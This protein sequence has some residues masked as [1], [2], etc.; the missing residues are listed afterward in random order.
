MTKKKKKN[1]IRISALAMSVGV[2][3][4]FV[5]RTFGSESDGNT[6]SASSAVTLIN[7]SVKTNTEDFFDENVVYKLSDNVSS[8]QE[9]SVIVAMN[10]D[11]VLDAYEA[12]DQKRSVKE[13][14]TTGEARTVAQ[15]T[16]AARNRL[17]K[18]L[19]KSGVKYVLGEKYDTV[20]SGFEITIK[21]KDFETVGGLFAADAT[22]ILGEVYAP[23]ESQVITNDVDVYDTGIFDSSASAYQGDGVVV[24][25]LDTG[26]DYTHTAFS[27]DNFTTSDEAFTL[28]TVAEKIGKTSAAKSSAGLSAEDVYV[29]KK[30]PYAYD[31]ADK[32]AD[33]APINSAHGTHVAGVIAGKDDTITGVAPNAQLA[34]MKVFSDTQDGAKTSWLLAALEDC[35]TL[36][37]DVINMS[38][39]SGCGFTREV[40]EEKVAEVCD[41]IRAAGI[42]LVVSAGNAYNATFNSEKNGNNGL[43]SNPDSGTVSSPSTYEASLSVASVDGVKT[44]YLM[45]GDDIIYFTEAATSDAQTKKSFVD[46]ILKTVGE[47]VTEHEFE[48]VT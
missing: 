3:S 1:A 23:A 19:N 35:V 48:Y 20:L 2:V 44:P 27:V 10:T 5:F 29:S 28:S 14:V 21:A 18:T 43:T 11:S 33:V 45:Y 38:L 9:I 36:G 37:V 26:L 34:I 15:Q 13:Y 24:A 40:D 8:S 4:G 12:S 31:Y 25:V 7:G 47:G 39:G 17:I 22:L 16:E 6:V 42:S 30:V 46:D 32:D 41:S